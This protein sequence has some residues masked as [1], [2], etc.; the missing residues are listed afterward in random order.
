MATA[1]VH[2]DVF[3]QL[4]Q[5]MQAD[6][7]VVT[8]ARSSVYCR[9]PVHSY[10]AWPHC[11]ASVRGKLRSQ[12]ACVQMHSSTSML[13]YAH[14][15]HGHGGYIEQTAVVVLALHAAALSSPQ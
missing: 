4:Q 1:K 10:S 3:E 14:T 11:C 2:W 9:S 13:S 6:S 8:A 15:L 7:V 12:H 5:H